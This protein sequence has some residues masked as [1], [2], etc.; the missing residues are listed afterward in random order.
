MLWRAPLWAPISR[1]SHSA[2]DRQVLKS[3]QAQYFVYVGLRL[4][5]RGSIW[6]LSKGLGC[7]RARG[8]ALPSRVAGAALWTGKC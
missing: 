6:E 7:W 4:R 8:C 2:L 3:W 5:G 1:G